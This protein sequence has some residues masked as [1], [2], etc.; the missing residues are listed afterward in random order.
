MDDDPFRLHGGETAAEATILTA[1]ASCIDLDIRRKRYMYRLCDVV[2][3]P[4]IA[5]LSE[6]DEWDAD[7]QRVLKRLLIPGERPERRPWSYWNR[8][9]KVAVCPDQQRWDDEYH[10]GVMGR[11]ARACW[12]TRELARHL[13]K[14]ITKPTDGINHPKLG[15]AGARPSLLR[16]IHVIDAWQNQRNNPYANV[17]DP[18]FLP[19]PKERPLVGTFEEGRRDGSELGTR[20]GA[21]DAET[22]STEHGDAIPPTERDDGRRYSPDY[23]DGWRDG[24]RQSYTVAYDGKQGAIAGEKAGRLR[25]E[26]DG[27]LGLEL[28]MSEMW[29]ELIGDDG[30]SRG[31]R[32]EFHDAFVRTYYLTLE[33]HRLTPPGPEPDPLPPDPDPPESDPPPK[34]FRAELYRALAKAISYKMAGKDVEA[35]AWAETLVQLLIDADILPES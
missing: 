7:M 20:L 22:G 2:Y 4:A 12:T 18:D 21:Q 17:P 16:Y 15:A 24:Y 8:L 26:Q 31:Y 3:L 6:A 32:Q 5:H 33:R 9:C 27:L 1:L 35:G 29:P 30:R 28:P 10:Y 23:R 11:V 14:V 25:G 13:P 19:P 34:D